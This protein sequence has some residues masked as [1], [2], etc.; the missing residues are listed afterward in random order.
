M[1]T[2]VYVLVPP[3]PY[4]VRKRICSRKH[5]R[6]PLPPNYRWK[7]CPNCRE[8]SRD[9]KRKDPASKRAPLKLEANLIPSRDHDA[10]LAPVIKPM[11]MEHRSQ[12]FAWANQLFEFAQ[13][14]K[15]KSLCPHYQ[16]HGDLLHDFSAR[17]HHL[18]DTQAYRSQM[19]F[20]AFQVIFDFG[21]EYSV[22]AQDNDILSR[23]V[24]VDFRVDG[25]V[26]TIVAAT[27]LIFGPRTFYARPYGVITRL[28]C[29]KMLHPIPA[30]MLG[31]LDIFVLPNHSHKYFP[32]EK[33]IVRFR[34]FGTL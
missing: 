1:A 18:I 31:E 27:G 34:L 2:L 14:L 17:L 20:S 28:C 7:R 30:Q 8:R 22:V 11:I 32:G 26:N 21:G 13:Q 33:T 10:N 6:V 23:K 25:V 12:H 5:C 9:Y 4:R 16:R 24:E 3:L 15:T 19:G 29:F